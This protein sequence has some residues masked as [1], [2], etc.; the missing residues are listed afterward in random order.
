MTSDTISVEAFSFHAFNTDG[1]CVFA[2]VPSENTFIH[3]Y[4]QKTK[5]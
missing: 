1:I 4:T 3:G 2:S 5:R